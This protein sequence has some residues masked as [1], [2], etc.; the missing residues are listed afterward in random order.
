MGAEKIAAFQGADPGLGKHEAELRR[1]KKRAAHM[2]SAEVETALAS[3][4]PVLGSA[5]NARTLLVVNDNNF[6]SVGARGEGLPND[7]EWIWLRL[8]RPR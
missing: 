4:S 7:T 5:S 3:F 8:P 6:P 1:L 2:L